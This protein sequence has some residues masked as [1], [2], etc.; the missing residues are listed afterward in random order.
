MGPPKCPGG[1]TSCYI[2]IARKKGVRDPPHDSAGR[3]CPT[4]SRPEPH[5][6][7]PRPTDPLDDES[8]NDNSSTPMDSKK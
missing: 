6:P 1:T 7:F 5:R 3:T 4:H 8:G 2:C